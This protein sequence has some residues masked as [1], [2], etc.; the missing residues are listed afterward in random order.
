MSAQRWFPFGLTPALSIGLLCADVPSAIPVPDST[1]MTPAVIAQLVLVPDTL[2]TNTPPATRSVEA[3][4]VEADG[5]TLFGLNIPFVIRDTGV[6]SIIQRRTCSKGVGLRCADI[7]L[8]QAGTTVVQVTKDGRSD[9][10]WIVVGTPAPTL[11]QIVVTPPTATL[12]TGAT[13]QFAAYGRLSNGDSVATTVTWTAT[14][15]TIGTGGSYKA[16]ALA[17]AYRVIGS[18][19]TGP[20]DTSA[21]TINEPPP[22]T[23][24]V[25]RGCPDSGYTRLV[26][27]STAAGLGTA[28]TNAQPGDQIRLAG[29][30][31]FRSTAFRF[32]K[33]G[34]AGNP[35]TICG[36]P[37]VMPL[38]KG[39][40]DMLRITGAY[41]HHG[42]LQLH[43]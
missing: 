8:K 17:G 7:R 42:Q 25:V 40:N 23:E 14:G 13:Q 33:S 37:G 18:H 26:N 28:L 10:T 22:P 1:G 6:A 20:A 35:I 30:T 16:G 43:P 31:Y 2:Q 11:T 15:G 3:F 9:S 21:V 32:D 12:D 24:N 41:Q 19:A 38:L 27:V 29:G 4:P 36:M 5:D 39:T 34:T